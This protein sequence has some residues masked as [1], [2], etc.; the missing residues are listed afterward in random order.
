MKKIF[1]SISIC[2]SIVFTAKASD[3]LTLNINAPLHP[4]SITYDTNGVW[5]ETYN[6]QDYMFVSFDNFEFSHLISGNSYGGTSW[7]GFTFSKNADNTAILKTDGVHFT[8][9]SFQDLKSWGNMAKGG[10]VTNTE[11]EPVIENGKVRT[12]DSIPYLT[13]YWSLYCDLMEDYSLQ[14][15]F[16]DK[17]Q[18]VGF[19]IN[20]SPF[21]YFSNM[22][23]DGFARALK[24]EGDYFKVIIHGLD[25]NF[26]DNGKSVE[27]TLTSFENGVFTINA[28][29]WEW[30]DLST[31][32]E[33]SG[34]YFTMASSDNSY[35]FMNTPAYFCMDKLSITAGNSAKITEKMPEAIHIFPNPCSDYLLMNCDMSDKGNMSNKSD[36]F[37]VQIYDVSGKLHISQL[38]HVSHI[39]Q[40]I[41]VA[42]LPSGT[43]FLKIA[44]IVKKFVKE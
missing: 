19:Y 35:G 31:L 22:Y 4:A 18:P 39:S 10:I 13:A 14:I 38:L 8:L 6:D 24:Q 37:L 1:T 40:K 41:N 7:E 25:E 3:T 21:A 23:G 42:D 32:G 20:A 33:C 16:H 17:Y 44:D 27:F 29:D 9:M 36:R 30:V 12:A 2:F 28:R 34:I 5:T 11:G 43:Y 15:L 26:D